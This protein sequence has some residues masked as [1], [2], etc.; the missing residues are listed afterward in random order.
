[1]L[2]PSYQ[3]RLFKNKCSQAFGTARAA[4]GKGGVI[5]NIASDLSVFSPGQLL[6]RR[7]GC[8][9]TCSLLNR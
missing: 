1:M 2:P 9:R 3:Y 8:R 5:L 6:Y 4:D 7:E